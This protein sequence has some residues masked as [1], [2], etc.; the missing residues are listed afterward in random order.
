MR[1]FYIDLLRVVSAFNVVLLHATAYKIYEVTGYE[2]NEFVV[3]NSFTRFAVPVFFM[4]SGA[5]GVRE[6]FSL[7]DL[8]RR[9][10]RISL[11][12][13]FWSV[14]CYI[15]VNVYSGG[16]FDVVEMTKAII[17]DKSMY[18]LWFLYSLL[19]VVI[20]LP[21][22]R[23]ALLNMALD[24]WRYFMYLICTVIFLRTLLI[25]FGFSLPT[26][27]AFL[28]TCVIYYCLGYYFSKND[29]VLKNLTIGVLGITSFAVTAALTIYYSRV[30]TALTEFYLCMESINVFIFSLSFFVFIKRNCERYRYMCDS[31]I[32]R[33]GV[34]FLSSGTFGCY[35]IHVVVLDK[36]YLQLFNHDYYI[37]SYPILASIVVAIIAFCI[38]CILG[39]VLSR[40]PYCRKI[41]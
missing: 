6:N 41:V 28:P 34:E 15:Y 30:N 35:L 40:L 21:F 32:I 4:V 22:L 11:P 31:F 25:M 38:S 27:F 24:E 12:L 19:S 23:R 14:M 7:S 8:V 16:M 9:I 18:H 37:S 10:A 13:I 5:V 26:S 29:I 20:L 1:Y 2:W 39:A 33:R 17:F 3:L 36:V